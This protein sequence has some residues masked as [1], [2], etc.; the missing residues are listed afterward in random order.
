LLVSPNASH[1]LTSSETRAHIYYS[2]AALAVDAFTTLEEDHW[3]A[4]RGDASQ[5]FAMLQ[6]YSHMQTHNR[7]ARS[8]SYL[9]EEAQLQSPIVLQMSIYM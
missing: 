4:M 6:V 1:T 2:S 5:C 8:G 7:Q 9:E 3:E